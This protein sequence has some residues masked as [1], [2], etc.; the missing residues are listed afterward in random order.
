MKAPGM[1]IHEAFTDVV[2]KI[3]SKFGKNGHGIQFSIVRITE[4]GFALSISA[5]AWS[6]KVMK[7]ETV[8]QVPSLRTSSFCS[9]AWNAKNGWNCINPTALSTR[10]QILYKNRLYLLWFHFSLRVNGVFDGYTSAP[11]SLFCE[12]PPLVVL[13]A[14]TTRAVL[15]FF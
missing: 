10:L 6:L 4:Q 11:R 15:A 8:I 9:T 14:K 12:S 2:V 13:E 7:I 5:L 3:M 1:H